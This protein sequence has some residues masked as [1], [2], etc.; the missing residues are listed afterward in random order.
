VGANQEIKEVTKKYFTMP[1][2]YG[3]NSPWWEGFEHFIPAKHPTLYKEHVLCK[4]CSTFCNNPDA[5]IVKIGVSQSTS[6]LWSHRKHNHLAEYDTITKGLNNNTKKSDGEGV[7]PASILNMPGF[8]AKVKVKDAKLLYRTA[9]TTLAIEE[10][11]PFRTFSQP[12]FRQLFIPLNAESDKIINLSRNDVRDSV[13]EMGG[14]VIEANKRKIRNHQILWTTDHWTGAEKGTYTTVTAHWINKTTW[15]LY[16][17]CL[18]FKV[19]EGST[20][21]ERIYKDIL[22]VLQT[23]CQVKVRQLKTWCP[24]RRLKLKLKLLHLKS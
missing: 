8:T 13:V 5:G 9:A 2:S 7:L 21:G 22:K 16:S 20:T 14:F 15:K 18:D 1:V 24:L 6:N 3:K 17:A 23:Y 4:E 10:G 19:F 12:S 11:I